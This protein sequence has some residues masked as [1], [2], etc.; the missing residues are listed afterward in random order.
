MPLTLEAKLIAT[1][2]AL[3]ALLGGALWLQHHERQIGAAECQ[4]KTA[5]ADSARAQAA[6]E[7][8]AAAEHAGAVASQDYQAQARA[9]ATRQPENRHA[10]QSALSAP[11]TCPAGAPPALADVL[12]PGDVLDGLRRAAGSSANP[13]AAR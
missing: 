4:A 9:I 8:F 12:V 13:A 7:Q 6:A 2:L 10:I 11:V 1:A 5:Q 3:L